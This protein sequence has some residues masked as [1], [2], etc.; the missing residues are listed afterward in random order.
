MLKGSE[1]LVRKFVRQL[2]TLSTQGAYAEY[3]RNVQPVRK[4]RTNSQRGVGCQ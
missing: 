2:R 3:A 1:L 4:E